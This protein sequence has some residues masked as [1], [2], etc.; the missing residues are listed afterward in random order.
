MIVGNL[1]SPR[2]PRRRL[3]W[4]WRC[5]WLRMWWGR[6]GSKLA[7][8]RSWRRGDGGEAISSDPDTPSTISKHNLCNTII[9][10]CPKV[11]V[12]SVLVFMKTMQKNMWRHYSL[13]WVVEDH[14]CL[15]QISVTILVMG[16]A[17]KPVVH[18][19]CCTNW[20]TQAVRIKVDLGNEI[21]WRRIEFVQLGKVIRQQRWNKL[22]VKTLIFFKQIFVNNFLL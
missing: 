11:N 1:A 10:L 21:G 16:F 17:S 7:R 4:R 8:R 22:L 5:R 2:S 14:F 6:P 9:Q 20:S 3:R 19:K 12:E 15:N 13:G 18:I